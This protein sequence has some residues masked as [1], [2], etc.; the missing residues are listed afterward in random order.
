MFELGIGQVV[1]SRFK[2][3]GDAEVGIFLVDV[4]CQGVKNAGVLRLSEW[5]Y[6][7]EVEDIYRDDPKEA[8]D[9]SSA[10]RL[11]EGAVAYAASF[12][13]AP[14]TRYR[15]TCCVFGGIPAKDSTAS[16]TFG[17]DGKPF[18]IQGPRDSVQRCK[19]ILNTLL[20]RCGEGNFDYRL[21][22]TESEMR[23]IKIAK[24]KPKQNVPIPPSAFPELYER[25]P[26][27]RKRL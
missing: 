19:H 18:F 21:Y 11:V 8:I 20:A 6:E 23:E 7:P 25:Q 13:F 12:S 1:I 9:P 24:F 27:E 26:T 4:F 2:A 5:Q 15:K 10:R 14:H 22:L 17:K 3:N 16:F